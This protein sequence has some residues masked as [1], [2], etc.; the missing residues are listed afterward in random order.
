MNQT[1]GHKMNDVEHQIAEI[2]SEVLKRKVLITDEVL[3][4]NEAKWDSLANLEI[5]MRIEE[6]L[7]VRFSPEQL[8][9]FKSKSSITLV[10]LKAHGIA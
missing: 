5:V 2:F 6:A 7:N 3:R 1:M 8:E 4:E 10:V 9:L